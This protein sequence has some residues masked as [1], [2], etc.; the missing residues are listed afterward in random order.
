MRTF[1][2]FLRLAIP[3]GLGYWLYRSLEVQRGLENQVADQRIGKLELE[4]AS[5]RGR[6]QE[7]ELI[8]AQARQAAPPAAPTAPVQASVAHASV[9]SARN[10]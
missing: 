6:R 7:A 8:A 9:N 3:W 5:E 4:L 1:L 10:V 2:L